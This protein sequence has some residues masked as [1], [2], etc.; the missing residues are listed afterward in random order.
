M[1]YDEIS[2]QLINETSEFFNSK[3]PKEMKQGVFNALK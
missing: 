2:D 3:K 1:D